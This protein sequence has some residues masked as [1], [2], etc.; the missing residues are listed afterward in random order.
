MSGNVVDLCPVGA[1]TNKPYAFNAR[2]WE[3]RSV[4]TIDVL[5][6]IGAS[7]RVDCRVRIY[8]SFAIEVS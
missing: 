1:L 5:D 3:L 8:R 7:I 6:A 2:P 4:E